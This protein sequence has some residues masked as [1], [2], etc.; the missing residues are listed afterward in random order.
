MTIEEI[1][2]GE[3]KDVEFTIDCDMLKFYNHDLKFVCEP[4]L[5]NIMT[6]PSSANLKTVQ[7][8]YQ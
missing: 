7:L 8:T 3:S 4:G 2:A 6:G 1:L 5:F